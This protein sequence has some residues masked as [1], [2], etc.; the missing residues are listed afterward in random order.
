MILRGE[1]EALAV[2][3]C[4]PDLVHLERIEHSSD[5]AH[6]RKWDKL[7]RTRAYQ[8]VLRDIRTIAPTGWYGSPG[9]ATG[10]TIREFRLEARD[11]MGA[12]ESKK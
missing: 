2:L 3:A 12:K 8:P 11:L 6:G 4:R 9:H 10:Q 7:R 5:P 1:I